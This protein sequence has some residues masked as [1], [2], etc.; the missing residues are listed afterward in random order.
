MAQVV[1][2]DFRRSSFN[3]RIIGRWVL[4]GYCRVGRWCRKH[5]QVLSP[6]RIKLL[7]WDARRKPGLTC[8]PM[9]NNHPSPADPARVASTALECPIKLPNQPTLA[10]TRS[11][12]RDTRAP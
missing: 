10:T 11:D 1:N 12:Q 9:P 4:A 6:R 2:T 3:L 7:R 5:L 8:R